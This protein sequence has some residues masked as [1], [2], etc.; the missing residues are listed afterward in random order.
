MKIAFLSTDNLDGYVT[1]DELTVPPLKESGY[2]VEIVSW[3]RTGVRWDRFAA[4]LIRSTW[5][6]HK[7]PG[8]FLRVLE[9]IESQTRLANPAEIVKWNFDKIYLRQLE[10]KGAVVVPT[11][12]NNG[13]FEREAIDRWFDHFRTDEIVIKPTISASA[14]GT[15]RLNKGDVNL[16]AVKETI[17]GRPCMIQPFMR[18]I[19]EEGE[20]SLQF[21]GGE[22]S[23]AILKSPKAADFRVQE[24][25]GGR[26]RQIEPTARL[27]TSGQ[28]VLKLLSQTPLYA[29]ADFVRDENDEFAL[30]ELELIEPSLYFRFDPDSPRRFVDAFLQ[31]LPSK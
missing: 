27:L 4:V 8:K 21:F 9:E 6:Y 29:R 16:T 20:Y 22:F 28:H 14:E 7:N 11:I 13:S 19:I 1:D 15:I 10:G 25:Y 26:N 3:R 23:H 30:M 5:D 31:W 17:K 24:E 12:W 18:G 2:D